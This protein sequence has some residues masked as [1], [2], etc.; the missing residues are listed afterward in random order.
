MSRCSVKC[1]T[2]VMYGVGLAGY[3][4]GMIHRRRLKGEFNDFKKKGWGE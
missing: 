2:S 3:E 1:W 4:W